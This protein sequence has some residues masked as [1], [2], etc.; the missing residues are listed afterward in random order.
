[1][2]APNAMQQ[3]QP[4][5]LI[6]VGGSHFGRY[7]KVSNEATWNFIVSDG[8]L[9]PYAGYSNVL[10][11]AT[12]LFGRGLYSSFVGNFMI[13]VI[14]S[15]VYKIVNGVSGLS[16]VPVGNLYTNANDVYIAENNNK[17]I[18]ITDNQFVYIYNYNNS[19]FYTSNP[20]SSSYF[21]FGY[22]YPA[23]VPS[24]NV[25]AAG[26]STFSNPGYVSFQG[27]QFFIAC[28]GSNNWV[29]SGANEGLIWPNTSPYV[30]AI[31]SK[32]DYCQA[33]V[34]MPGG[35]NNILVFAQNVAECWQ[36]TSSALFPFQRNNTFNIDYGCLN[37]ASIASLKD[38]VVWLAVNQQ[39]GPV[40]MVSRG[41]SIEPISTDGIDY[42]LG[43]LTD[44]ENCT[45]FLYQQ[46][47][48]VVYQFTFPTDNISY[49]YDFETKLFFN[50]SDENLDYHPAREVAYFNNN[51]Y[52]VSLDGG[53]IYEFSTNYSTAQ[54]SDVANYVIPRI[55]ICPPLRLPSQ[56]YFII[57]EIGF[58]MEMGQPNP[59]TITVIDDAEVGI[60]L[61][62]ESFKSICTESGIIID[63]EGDTNTT[64]TF[65]STNKVYLAISRNG[66]ETYGSFW[67]KDMNPTGHYIN[68]F[69]YQRCGHAND[70]S[71]QLRFTGTSRYV[72]TNGEVI[73]YE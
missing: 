26:A 13:G 2:A 30:G 15:V 57:K 9:V 3:I 61:A 5:P 17:E 62:T 55:R 22:P 52:F 59:L 53:N 7:P 33:V 43:N 41:N 42:Q 16:A 29:L 34:P 36:R 66:G 60:Q 65:D 37:P 14:G 50:V 6:I 68:R 35:G 63:V 18:C 72:A 8:F 20:A 44:P 40:V 67:E 56:A 46:D 19:S 49:A 11:L 69:R 70:A 10:T 71:I 39:S 45:G 21:P 4:I 58:T 24:N 51:Y 31:Q 64:T 27:G 47:G 73:I 12:A 48:H 54:Y 32:P 23:P 38:Y 1:M 28:T 25:P